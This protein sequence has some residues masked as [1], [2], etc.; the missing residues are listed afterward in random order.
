MAG[1]DFES[2]S[3]NIPLEK[4]SKNI[5]RDLFL[6]GVKVQSFAKNGISLNR[7]NEFCLI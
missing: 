2:H 3:T 5:I 7:R 6:A 1:L 4:K